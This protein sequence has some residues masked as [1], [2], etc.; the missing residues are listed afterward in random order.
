MLVLGNRLDLFLGQV[1][2]FYAIL[3][4]H[5]ALVFPPELFLG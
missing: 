5:N 1:A 2:Q 3:I 4:A